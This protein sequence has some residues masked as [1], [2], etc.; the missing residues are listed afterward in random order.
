LLFPCSLIIMPGTFA[1][2]LWPFVQMRVLRRDW[3]GGAL[4]LAIMG[5][6]HFGVAIVAAASVVV[7]AALN[8]D[9]ARTA[10]FVLGLA[11]VLFSPWLI[12][13]WR[14]REFLH[15]GIADLPVFMPVITVAGLICGVLAFVRNRD[16]EA[17]AVLAMI[18]ASGLFLLT[19]RE[20]FWTYGGLLFALLGGYGLDR[21]GGRHLKWIVPV[22]CA[23]MLSVTPFLK[24]PRMKLAL[25]V[26][27]QSSPLLMGTPVS[28]LV[29]WQRTPPDAVAPD[30]VALTDWIAKN[31]PEDEIVITDE[32][33]LGEA[34]FVLTG[35][36]TTAGLWTEVMTAALAEKLAA[37]RRAGNGYIVVASSEPP[38][39]AALVAEFGRYRVF[40]RPAFA[41]SMLARNSFSLNP[42]SVRAS[43][44]CRS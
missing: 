29:A 19:V 15:S 2:L 24:P 23:S 12:H 34:I 31:V 27:A 14:H 9:T 10:V 39:R 16:N 25:P 41:R 35:R 8:R 28:T 6:L 37:Y 36:R 11:A 44:P 21:L 40:Y 43:L 1:V 18:L 22:L 38:E 7:L 32:R 4:M 17:L 42:A 5:Y 20:R 13:L 26:P 3:M 30:I 33:L